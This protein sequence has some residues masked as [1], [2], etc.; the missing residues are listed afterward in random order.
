MAATHLIAVHADFEAHWP[1]VTQALADAWSHVP[2]GLQVLRWGR[3]D[4][5][6]LSA[7]VQAAGALTHAIVLGVPVTQACLDV[8]SG[9][10]Q[11]AFLPAY[12][13]RTALPGDGMARLRARGV[14]LIEHH[15]EGFWG[16]SVAEFALGLTID[17]LR[18]M[19]HYSREMLNSLEAWER[20]S[21]ARN[22][23]PGG[24]G[25][26]M[27]DDTRF[28]S[29]TIAGKR[30]RVVGV[31]NIGSRYASFCHALGA[32]VAAWDPLASD[33]A[34]HRSGARRVRPIEALLGDAQIFAPMMPL[35]DATR[36][37]VTAAHVDAL[38]KGCLVVVVTRM[39]IIDA[40]A[41]RRRVLANELALAADVFDIEPLPFDD[42]LL[43]RE[44]VTHTPHLAGRTVD[45][46]IAWARAILE[47][48]A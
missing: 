37:I 33:P 29:G 26:Q 13:G 16:Q 28:T 25:A 31:G 43:G 40:P 6:P 5:Q 20:Y 19:Q 1:F 30:V 14:A 34:F 38:P 17:A 47:Q 48:F 45:A 15:S 44:N 18:R 41:L 3:G 12:G 21:A 36:G 32:D 22:A 23:G 39:G 35:V 8:L 46:N 2:G 27:S 9:L 7:R 10:R 42:P 11:A 4:A 24:L